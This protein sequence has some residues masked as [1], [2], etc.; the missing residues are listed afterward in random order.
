MPAIALPMLPIAGGRL[1]TNQVVASSPTPLSSAN[2]THHRNIRKALGRHFAT[3]SVTMIAG[4]CGL[5][6]FV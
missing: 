2:P 3:L 5:F 4:N 6:V 1:I